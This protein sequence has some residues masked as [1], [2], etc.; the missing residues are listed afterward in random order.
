MQQYDITMKSLLH[1]FATKAIPHLTGTRVVA[2]RNVELPQAR[3][4][5]VDLLGET[6]DGR[7]LHVESEVCNTPDLPWRMMGY[8]VRIHEVEGRDTVQVVYY[9][10]EAPLTME[11]GLA[12]PGL[13]TDLNSLM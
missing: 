8:R 5:R 7:L 10:G 11:S 13:V 12:L 1:D 2:W 4:L 3:N 9:I 6:D